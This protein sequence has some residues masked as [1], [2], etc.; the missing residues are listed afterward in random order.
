MK[1]IQHPINDTIRSLF[2]TPIM[3]ANNI[4]LAEAGTVPVHIQGQYLR[5]R[6]YA[7]FINYGSCSTFP[8][9][10]CI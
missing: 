5:E 1:E 10:G 7:R 4:M 3:L 9:H 8:L 2:R 6:C